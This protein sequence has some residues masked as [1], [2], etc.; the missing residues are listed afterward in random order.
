ME[1]FEIIL[2][3]GTASDPGPDNVS[4]L[5]NKSGCCISMPFATIWIDPEGVY[6]YAKYMQNKSEKDNS[7]YM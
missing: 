6:P 1:I 7:T 4:K 3:I 5:Q 2:R